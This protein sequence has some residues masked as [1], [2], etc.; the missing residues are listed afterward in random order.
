MLPCHVPSN[1]EPKSQ[2]YAL[3]TASSQELL[4]A[5]KR[6]DLV[7]SVEQSLA[8]KCSENPKIPTW[9]AYSSQ[10]CST[11]LTVLQQA[12]KINTVIMGPDRKPVITF[13]LQLY[14]MAV[15]LQIHIAPQLNH[16]IFRLGEMHTVM[17]SLRALT[18]PG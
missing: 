2:S 14:E 12:Q 6:D 10:I 9:A 13:D 1:I 11:M 16:L 15:K 8:R 5:A 4:D 3:D 18:M 7:W 17:T